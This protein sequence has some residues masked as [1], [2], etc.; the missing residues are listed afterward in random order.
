MGHIVPGVGWI[1]HDYLGID[2]GPIVAMIENHRSGLVWNVMRRNEH[3]RRGLKRA[4][5]TGGWLDQ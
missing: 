1:D 5:F 4:G 2:Q 3:V